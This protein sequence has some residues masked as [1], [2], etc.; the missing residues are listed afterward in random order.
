M[1]WLRGAV[2]HGSRSEHERTWWSRVG[3]RRAGCRQLQ[4]WKRPRLCRCIGR[5]RR[6][7]HSGAERSELGNVQRIRTGRIFFKRR[8]RR[9]RRCVFALRTVGWWT[10]RGN[11]RRVWRF[12]WW[13][14]RS[15]QHRR[16]CWQLWDGWRC[17]PFCGH[18][19]RCQRDR[20]Q[21]VAVWRQ[22]RCCGRRCAS[23]RRCRGYVQRRRCAGDQWSGS[24]VRRQW[25]GDSGIGGL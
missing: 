6:W 22:W 5:W 21:R 19:N 11:R 13:R 8:L 3:G 10:K 15:H 12:V 18:H 7:Q 14:G 4:R 9:K 16:R 2:V 20:R 24:I 25:L 17:D 23:A 1:Q